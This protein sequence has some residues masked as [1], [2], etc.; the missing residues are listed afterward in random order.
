VFNEPLPRNYRRGGY[1]HR[2]KG[3]FM[4]LLPFFQNTEIKINIQFDIL[5]GAFLGELRK[6]M[7]KYSHYTWFLER[8]LHL[9]PLK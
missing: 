2:Q 4:A 8:N 6:T 5:P 1:K 3:D 7:M 9:G